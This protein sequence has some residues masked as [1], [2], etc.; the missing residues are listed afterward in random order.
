MAA[1]FDKV[2]AK[3]TQNLLA[4]IA[5]DFN[6][7]KEELE[8]KFMGPK[9]SVDPSV[10][11]G[12]ITAKKTQC[13]RKCLAGQSVCGVHLKKAEPVFIRKD[14]PGPSLSVDDRIK[15]IMDADEDADTEDEAEDVDEPDDEE[16]SSPG[17][18]R[19]ALFLKYQAQGVTWD[20]YYSQ[21][22]PSHLQ[23]L[24]ERLQFLATQPFDPETA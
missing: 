23:T 15:A 17:G 4:Q 2:L 8:I 19:H 13:T 10:Q 6:L 12:F 3:Y 1:I 7:P 16:P 14:D 24:E 22:W 20:R 11:C 5:L 18:V 9:K 21:Q